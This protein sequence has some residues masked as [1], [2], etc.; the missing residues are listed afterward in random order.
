MKIV[1]MQVYQFH[2]LS[3]EAKETARAW[4]REG[5]EYTWGEEALLSLI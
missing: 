3:D 4:W 1:E 5:W 2:E